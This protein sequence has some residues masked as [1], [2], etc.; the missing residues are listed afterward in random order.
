MEGARGMEGVRPIPLRPLTV[1]ELLDGS[2]GAV[3]AL[4]SAVVTRVAVAAGVSSLAGLGV[5]WAFDA[6]IR[7]AVRVHPLIRTDDFGVT[8]VQ[9]GA[10]GGDAKFGIF[11]VSVLIPLVFSGFAAT[12]AAGLLARPVKEYIDGNSAAPNAGNGAGGN[13][14]TGNGAA[15][16]GSSAH[17]ASA[18]PGTNVASLLRLCIL[19][20]IAALPRVL[21]TG[22]LMLVAYSAANDQSGD[23]AGAYALL[24][25]G[26]LVLCL[27]LTAETAVAAPAAV[28][29]GLGPA[30]ALG[31]GR[32]LISA[33]RWRVMWTSLLTLGISSVA[34]ISLIVLQYY[35]YYQ[36]GI[37]DL[38]DGASVDSSTYWWLT[39]DVAVAVLLG[40]LTVPFRA[41]VAAMLYVDRRFRREGLDIRIAWARVARA[42]G[43]G[44]GR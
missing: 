33:G 19:A 23:Y 43:G 42:N 40:V 11:V 18:K 10:A 8:T 21:F 9:Y 12:V 5:L 25:L 22:V 6:T 14:A 1:L 20:T 4:S 28:L 27:W 31:R 39:A 35:I 2:I 38:L 24:I 32:R 44:K 3:R 26:G 7:G 17:A 15:G 13:G 36:H 34:T 16:N 29:E 41:A 30:S 37:S